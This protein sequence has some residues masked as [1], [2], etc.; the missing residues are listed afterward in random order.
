MSSAQSALGI[1]CVALPP[2]SPRDSCCFTTV[3][4]SQRPH[5]TTL[6]LCAP[7]PYSFTMPSRLIIIQNIS[8]CSLSHGP[9]LSPPPPPSLKKP[10]CSSSSFTE[11]LSYDTMPG[12]PRPFKSFQCLLTGNGRKGSQDVF[13]PP[14][15][16]CTT[17]ASPVHQDCCGR[18]DHRPMSESS[19]FCTASTAPAE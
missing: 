13:S 19:A 8:S 3:L 17:P 9:I 4:P 1:N 6:F 15:S 10:Q 11:S 18:C 5:P 2:C 14:L 12:T 16:K 7:S